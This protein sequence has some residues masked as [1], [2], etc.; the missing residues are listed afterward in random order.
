LIKTRRVAVLGSGI[1]G[2]TLALA[3]ARHGQDVTLFDMEER[4]FERASRWN[5]GKIHLGYLYS[6]H[7]TLETARH[8]LPG[9]LAFKQLTERFIGCSLESAITT[10]DD[11]YLIHRDS[12]TT[13]SAMERYVAG[14]DALLAENNDSKNYLVDL[15]GRRSHRIDRR[16]LAQDY[17]V[18][19]IVAGF[20]VPERSV[21]TIWVADKFLSALQA[22]PKIRLALH[23]RVESVKPVDGSMTGPF[24]IEAAGAPAETFDLVINALWEGRLAI[25]A[26]LGILPPVPWSHR[27]RLSLFVTT[28]EAVS[29]PSTVIAAGPFGDI[30]Q[31]PNNTFYLSWYPAGLQADGTAVEPPHVP[32]MNEQ[33]RQNITEEIFRRLGAIIPGVRMIEEKAAT[34]RLEG[35]WVYAAGQGSLADPASSLHRRDRGN[36]SRVGHYVSV[37][38]G[39]YSIA[40][41]LAEQIADEIC[42]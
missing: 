41:W 37:D 11:T 31:Y 35:G 7:P 19:D 40:P 33:T 16:E 22:E 36:I 6:A 18:T 10:H 30:K 5:E 13:A 29:V 12:V 28:R 21:S 23:Q 2:S 8:L 15:R 4:P 38:T 17:D 42:G 20:R 32:G 39:K 3:L 1:M 14:V 26:R 24:R 34:T 27:F 25:D 9:G